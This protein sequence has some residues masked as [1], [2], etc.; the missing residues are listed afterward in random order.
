M[1]APLR[2]KLSPLEAEMLSELRVAKTVP[3]R[4]RDRAHMLRLNA[5]GWNVPAIAEVFACHEHTV[6][7]TIKRWQAKGLP[8]LWESP[9]RGAKR[10]WSEDDLA[11][12][13]TCLN[14]ETRTY[15][16]AQLAQKLREER[17]VHLS[18]DRVR[19]IL[20]KKLPMETHPSQPSPKA[21]S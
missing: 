4:T 11:Y 7:A 20:K 19:R 3:Q 21:K 18:R 2:V 16:S 6:R 9:G 12:L 1:P 17:T 13:E 10:R 15:N 5:E 14:D 8:G